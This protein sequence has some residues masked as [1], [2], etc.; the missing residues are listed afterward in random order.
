MLV[1]LLSHISH[2]SEYVTFTVQ[3]IPMVGENKLSFTGYFCA[4]KSIACIYHCCLSNHTCHT[5]ELFVQI[6][7]WSEVLGF[8]NMLSCSQSL[9]VSEYKTIKDKDNWI[10][11]IWNNSNVFKKRRKCFGLVH[12]YYFD[13]IS[14]A[15]IDLFD[16]VLWPSKSNR[17]DLLGFVF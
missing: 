5:C 16:L 6:I 4:K 10:L 2:S 8:V 9:T 17:L 14:I 11:N 7:L 3:N 12:W 13:S 15:S 1:F